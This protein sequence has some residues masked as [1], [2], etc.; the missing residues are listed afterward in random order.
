MCCAA[1]SVASVCEVGVIIM[2]LHTGWLTKFG[3]IILHYFSE[4]LAFGAHWHCVK[5]AEDI[6]KLS[7]TETQSKASSF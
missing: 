3:T 5:V 7:A 1:L 2:R 6:L 4:T